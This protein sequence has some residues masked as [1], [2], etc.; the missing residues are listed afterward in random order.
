MLPHQVPGTG[1]HRS[2]RGR[3]SGCGGIVS[4]SHGRRPRATRPPTR[5][6]DRQL[7]GPPRVNY[8]AS[9]RAAPIGRR[10]RKCI[11]KAIFGCISPSLVQDSKPQIG[12]G[13]HEAARRAKDGPR[14]R[15]P[16]RIGHVPRDAVLRLAFLD[17]R[18]LATINSAARGLPSH[19][20]LCFPYSIPAFDHC[21]RR[22]GSCAASRAAMKIR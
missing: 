18:A 13:N 22:F 15:R 17:C 2:L 3:R 4:K 6:C 11:E 5:T 20:E 21:S 1:P 14:C 9:Y 19:K 10:L 8:A 12:R 7:R 16:R